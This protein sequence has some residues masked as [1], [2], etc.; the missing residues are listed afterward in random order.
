MFK[1][2]ESI[3]QDLLLILGLVDDPPAPTS[4]V[5]APQVE[6]DCID[7]SDSDTGSDTEA[8]EIEAVLLSKPEQEITPTT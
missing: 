5:G 8:E 1:I 3:P 4:S 2:P 7:S 6:V